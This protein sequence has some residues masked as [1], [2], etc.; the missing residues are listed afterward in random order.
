MKPKILI[1]ILIFVTVLVDVLTV[2]FTRENWLLYLW[3]VAIPLSILTFLVIS[4]HKKSGM[5]QT[6][7]FELLIANCVVCVILM[8]AYY[9][10]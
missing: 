8:I 4:E 10:E 3:M 2:F 7:L 9:Y 1:P 6:K 5:N